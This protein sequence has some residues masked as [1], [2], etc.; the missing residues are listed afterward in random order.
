MREAVFA[1]VFLL[2]SALI[3]AVLRPGED[4]LRPLTPQPSAGGDGHD[5]HDSHHH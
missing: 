4:Q 1:A 2:V 5:H 3:G